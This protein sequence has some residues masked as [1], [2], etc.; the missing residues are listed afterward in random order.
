MSLYYVNVNRFKGTLAQVQAFSK[1][2]STA[3]LDIVLDSVVLKTGEQISD[4]FA[5][6][7]LAAKLENQP[8]DI[9]AY[10]SGGKLATS[11]SIF[12]HTAAALQDLDL[13][14]Q[15]TGSPVWISIPWCG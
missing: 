12:G 10:A 7:A 3:E 4:H 1:G 15:S 6:F 2:H 8:E 14:P 9:Y 13:T 11:A 5:I